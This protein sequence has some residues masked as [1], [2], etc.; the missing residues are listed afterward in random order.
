MRAALVKE[1]GPPSSIVVEDVPDLT[2][3][4]GEVVIDVAAVSINFP[5]ILV[6]EGTYQNLPSRPFSPGKEA[7]GKVVAVGPGVQRVIVGQR[8]LVLVEYGGYAE[9]L[10]APEDL[11][12]QIPDSMSYEEAAAFGLVYSTAYFGLFRRGQLAMGETV[13]VTGVGG[14]VGSAAVQLAKTKGCRVIALAQDDAKAQFARELGADI[15]L[16]STPES[17]RDDLLAATDGNGVDVVLEM[18]GGDYF[19]QIIRATAWE[20]RI[21]IVGFASGGQNPIK[22]GHILVKSISLIGLVSSDY[23]DRAPA[24]MRSTMAEMFELFD[25]GKLNA[26]VDTTFPLDKVGDALQYVKDGRVKGKVVVTTGRG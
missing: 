8:V 6:V 16:T 24:L 21:V 15:V 13:L 9:Q 11:V 20:G 7:A 22:P 17:L 25:Q 12:M 10:L 18:L 1:F 2:P 5:D 23:R 19:T 3:G 26:A 14:G 4:P